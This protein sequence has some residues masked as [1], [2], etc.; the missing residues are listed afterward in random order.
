MSF[1]CVHRDV[2]VASDSR[3]VMEV[4]A[5]KITVPGNNRLRPNI[6]RRQTIS[7]YRDSEFRVLLSQ[8]SQNPRWLLY[9]LSSRWK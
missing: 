2:D 8:W 7:D 5:W 3:E 1:L 4:L 9:L 6:R